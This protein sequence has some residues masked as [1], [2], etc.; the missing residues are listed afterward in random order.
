MKQN[1]KSY[2][3]SLLKGETLSGEEFKKAFS[4]YVKEKYSLVLEGPQRQRTHRLNEVYNFAFRVERDAAGLGE[5]TSAL[6]HLKKV[7]NI[8]EKQAR[9]IFDEYKKQCL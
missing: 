6:K 3:A 4:I 5:E 2:R 1:C 8:D 7:L 9:G